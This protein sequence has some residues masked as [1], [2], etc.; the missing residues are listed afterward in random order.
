M[1]IVVN[2]EKFPK[3]SQIFGIFREFLGIN[4]QILGSG[5]DYDVKHKK[6]ERTTKF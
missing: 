5:G 4:S 2:H 6:T 3:N 1:F